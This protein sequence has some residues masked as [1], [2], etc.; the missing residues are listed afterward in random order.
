MSEYTLPAWKIQQLKKFHKRLK[1]K[2]EA[3]RIN[4]IILLGEGWT[5]P[6]VAKVLLLSEGSVRTYFKYF[7]QFGK[8]ELIKRDYT[9]RESFLTEEQE[10][11]LSQHLEDNLY[12]R[13]QDIQQ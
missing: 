1:Q 3:Y 11:E 8:K 2:H 7:Q 9:G 10:Q 13:S 12:Q 5:P 6:Q 4:A